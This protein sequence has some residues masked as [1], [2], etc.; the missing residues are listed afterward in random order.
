MALGSM[1]TMAGKGCIYITLAN[2]DPVRRPDKRDY[3]I[4]LVNS[5]MFLLA[6]MNLKELEILLRIFG[7]ILWIIGNFIQPSLVF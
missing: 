4:I 1:E 2:Q 7:P 6:G 3:F 5:P